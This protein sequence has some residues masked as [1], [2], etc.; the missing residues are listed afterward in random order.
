MPSK[1]LSTQSRP[2]VFALLALC[3][4]ALPM[5][6]CQQNRSVPMMRAHGN[7]AFD[8]G[9]YSDAIAFQRRV[10]EMAPGRAEYR[11]ELGRSLRAAGQPGE[12]AEQ[13]AIAHGLNP[14]SEKIVREYAEALIEI[15]RIDVLEE[16][17]LERARKSA[18]YKDAMILGEYL[19]KAGDPDGAEQAFLAAADVAGQSDPAPQRALARFY[20]KTNQ[21]R[22]ALRRW[23]MVL[24]FNSQDE[25]ASQALRDAGEIPGPTASLI[26]QGR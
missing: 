18:S 24:W 6:G 21:P 7:Q 22:E 13:L 15:Q 5:L 2:V 20:D 26:P 23:K 1:P 11:Y 12:A 14:E 19:D 8:E 25:E 10:N 16:V 4:L 17:L 9:R 3:T